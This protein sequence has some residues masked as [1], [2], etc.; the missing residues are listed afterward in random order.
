MV[1]R[2]RARAASGRHDLM[3]ASDLNTAVARLHAVSARTEERLE[4]LSNKTKKA[5]FVS[6]SYVHFNHNS[7]Y[8]VP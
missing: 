3:Q 1:P 4:S 2:K 8:R 7:N 6:S 5:G